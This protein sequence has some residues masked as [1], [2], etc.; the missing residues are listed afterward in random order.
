MA[1]RF[2][3]TSITNLGNVNDP[4]LPQDA[5]TKAY[6]DALAGSLNYEV[7]TVYTNA[8]V[9]TATITLASIAPIGNILDLAV[10][11]GTGTGAACGSFVTTKGVGQVW[12]FLGSNVTFT[13]ASVIV[14]DADTA[15]LTF[16]SAT[17]F[18]VALPFGAPLQFFVSAQTLTPFR[19]IIAGAGVGASVAPDADLVPALT[20]TASGGGGGSSVSVNG[21][22]IASPNF[23]SNPVALGTN[24]TVAGSNITA[25]V[26]DADVS[27]VADREVGLLIGSST[28][29]VQLSNGSLATAV[30]ISNVPGPNVTMTIATVTTAS[31]ILSVLTG[32]GANATTISNLF[33]LGS[34]TLVDSWSSPLALQIVATFPAATTLAQVQAV[35]APGGVAVR[36]DSV[37]YGGPTTG[38]FLFQPLPRAAVI[39]LGGGGGGTPGGLTTQVQFN[40]N[41]VFGGSSNLVWDGTTLSTNIIGAIASPLSLRSTVAVNIGDNFANSIYMTGAGSGSLPSIRT[42]STTDTNVNL[43]IVPLGTGGLQLG[44]SVIPTPL[45]VA[46]SAT[47][48]PSI[49]LTPGIA[50]QI[51]T[52]AGEAK[53]P[54]WAALSAGAINFDSITNTFINA[55]VGTLA[56]E[57]QS[58]VTGLTTSIVITNEGTGDGALLKAFFDNNGTSILYRFVG[59]TI[60][61]SVASTVALTTSVT[62]TLGAPTNFLTNIPALT[63]LQVQQVVAAPFNDVLLAAPLSG[64]VATGALGRATLTITGGVTP[65]GANTQIQFNNNGVL[66][67]SAGL[68]WNGTQLGTN[69]I[70]AAASSTLSLRSDTGVRIQDQLANF[71]GLNGNLAGSSPSIEAQG[72][73]TNVNLIVYGKGTGGIQIGTL[74]NATPLIAADA[75]VQ[76]ALTPGVSGQILT[77]S[78]TG[79]TPYWAAL[80][81]GAINFDSLTNAFV[82]AIVS[83]L[84][85]ECLSTVAGL[86]TTIVISN[87]G[88]GAGPAIKTF[89]DNNGTS[90]FYRFT[91]DTQTFTVASTISSPSQVTITLGTPTNFLGNIPG[92][93]VL[94]VQQV[95]ARPFNDLVLNAPLSGV[96]ATGALGRATLTITGGV[97]PGG[98][99]TQIQFNNNGAL[100]GSASL[101]WLGASGLQLGTLATPAPLV[102][103]DSATPTTLTPG[104][105]G[106]VLTSAGVGKTPYWSSSTPSGSTTL[107]GLT[108]VA[109]TEPVYAQ[110]GTFTVTVVT[111]NIQSITLS[112]LPTGLAVGDWL[113]GG[114]VLPGQLPALQVIFISGNSLQFSIDPSAFFAVGNFVYKLPTTLEGSALFFSN[115]QN[116]WIAEPPNNT[117]P[118]DTLDWV[119]LAGDLFVTD[120][121]VAIFDSAVTTNSVV[122]SNP[123]TFPVAILPFASRSEI[124]GIDTFGRMVSGKYL[125]AVDSGTPTAVLQDVLIDRRGG[126]GF[127]LNT[128]YTLSWRQGK[129]ALPDY[130]RFNT[131]TNAIIQGQPAVDGRIAALIGS[132]PSS[133]TNSGTT[134]VTSGF[135]NAGT[136][137]NII[138]TGYATAKAFLQTPAIGA[139]PVAGGL[140]NWTLPAGWTIR[141]SNVANPTATQLASVTQ[142]TE[143]QANS[144]LQIVFLGNASYFAN[145][146]AT[147]QPLFFFGTSGFIFQP[148]PAGAIDTEVRKLQVA[149]N[150]VVSALTDNYSLTG[151]AAPFFSRKISAGL[152][153]F[154][155][156]DA[157]GAARINATTSAGGGQGWIVSIQISWDLVVAS[158]IWT[159]NNAFPVFFAD[160]SV[161]TRFGVNGTSYLGNVT[162]LN[163]DPSPT[164]RDAQKFGNIYAEWHNTQA[165]ALTM[166]AVV[167]DAYNVSLQTSALPNNVNPTQSDAVVQALFNITN[168]NSQT[169]GAN[170]IG[171]SITALYAYQ[172]ARGGSGTVV[173]TLQSLTDVSIVEPVYVQVGTITVTSVTFATS[174]ILVSDASGI[175]VGDWLRGGGSFPGQLPALK[176]SSKTGNSIQFAFDPTP[177]FAIGNFVYRLPATLDG[178]PLSFSN[179]TNKWVAGTGGSSIGSNFTSFVI[180]N[181]GTG[182]IVSYATTYSEVKHS[183]IFGFG[184][185]Q[186]TTALDG[187]YIGTTKYLGT[188]QI[189]VTPGYGYAALFPVATTYTTIEVEIYTPT[190]TF[191]FTTDVITRPQDY[192]IE[193]VYFSRA[194][195]TS[196][197][198]PYISANIFPGF[199][200]TIPGVDG[201][202]LVPI[203]P[204]EMNVIQVGT[205]GMSFS[206]TITGG[207]YSGVVNNYNHTATTIPYL[208]YYRIW[209]AFGS[210]DFSD[211]TSIVLD[212]T[213]IGSYRALLSL[214]TGGGGGGGNQNLQQVL[215]LGNRVVS[216]TPNVGSILLTNSATSKTTVL[217]GTKVESQSLILD[218]ATTGSLILTVPATT[219]NYSLT[220]PPAQATAAGQTL[221]NNGSGTLSWVTPSGGGGTPGG[222][223]NQFQYNNAGAFAGTVGLTFDSVNI[224]ASAMP[225]V[226]GDNIARLSDV[227][228][229]SAGIVPR[230]T[231]GILL[232]IAEVN[233]AGTYSNNSGSVS[234][235]ATL[236]GLVQLTVASTVPAVGDEVLLVAQTAGLQNGS[237]VVTVNGVSGF[238]LTRT[239]IVP[240]FGN[241]WVA[242]ARLGTNYGTQYENITTGTITVGTTPILYALFGVPNNVGTQDLQA[243]CNIGPTTTTAMNV[244]GPLTA[245][246]TSGSTGNVIALAGSL[247]GI[248]PSITASGVDANVGL[249]IATK[250]IGALT[251]S[252]SVTNIGSNVNT[253]RILST[254]GALSPIISVV[255]SANT[256]LNIGANGTGNINLGVNQN[257]Y[258]RITPS[259][260]TPTITGFGITDTSLNIAPT[261][262]GKVIIGNTTDYTGLTIDSAGG[263]GTVVLGATGGLATG[264]VSIVLLPKG[265]GDIFPLGTSLSST[266]PNQPGIWLAANKGATAVDPGA[267]GS[268]MTSNY[269]DSSPY[270]GFPGANMT[271]FTTDTNSDIT[272]NGKFTLRCFLTA[273]NGLN[274]SVGTNPILNLSN[275]QIT[276]F[277]A[278]ATYMINLTFGW[279]VY[280]TQQRNVEAYCSVTT[281]NDVVSSVPYGNGVTCA[282][283][284]TDNV[285][286]GD[287]TFVSATGYYVSGASAQTLYCWVYMA[288]PSGGECINTSVTFTRI[289]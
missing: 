150:I 253:V 244:G 170:A 61:F 93:T 199:A 175:S 57:C 164:L 38:T 265:A 181:G 206:A 187:G 43:S 257:N 140:G 268:V 84:V 197:N 249:Q 133:Y 29:R 242:T 71:I 231:A 50:G 25:G 222:L 258:I 10:S 267:Y 94:Q 8:T 136:T 195:T 44:T 20:L 102:V 251:L 39:A 237:Y 179:A 116:K 186:D 79:K 224:R 149:P 6:T 120:P 248:A 240:A 96:V 74:S 110:V 108:D 141:I 213:V 171:F 286:V 145:A 200:Q 5:S 168:S 86:T 212:P 114:T 72:S 230:N 259:S 278:N 151:D 4:I 40:N 276:G 192:V 129:F 232:H 289:A 264:S 68:T 112:A 201:I 235:F 162:D 193:G 126:G 218:G 109:I 64:V 160:G 36:S 9:G 45:I 241:F 215:N 100:G 285:L 173:T 63:N 142:I 122:F 189:G 245:G 62:I 252:A 107:Q 203:T 41:G 146:G 117:L 103:V 18:G 19:R 24:L 130:V 51:L 194:D 207:F 148:A 37:F 49:T 34:T 270:W 48:T 190:L 275:G 137:A 33:Q 282:S 119:N 226:I 132:V 69:I 118:L 239:S 75:A 123:W 184:I 32:L 202:K 250:G 7:P 73:D 144:L 223:N 217:D 167:E 111:A 55:L 91:G 159:G 47:Q 182:T 247:V 22:L 35:F 134:T 21:V 156:T 183:I 115:A 188:T 105:T 65:G 234:P 2:D 131:A 246:Y 157:F 78:G 92:L 42:R 85:I 216:S 88:T 56:V 233:I 287:L 205:S 283:V 12:R 273:I 83:G 288:N 82:D 225:P 209:S 158:P 98:A 163:W 135:G 256:S 67:G 124:V 208:A 255:G 138:T 87:Q 80:S 191:N 172:R 30:V 210:P 3:F 177:F 23:Q 77:S 263:Q 28:N 14:V 227:Q 166:M 13:V 104:T 53:T 153:T 106:Q 52:S 274:L 27:T 261:G 101:A 31:T 54:Y 89:F 229:A 155:D 220:L 204:A 219:S 97:T 198:P 196:G 17:N 70:S 26:R 262:L 152:N 154:W 174:S 165:N 236:V 284:R 214:P 211:P 99:N 169:A 16:G 221:S 260:T 95:V 143:N 269:T 76:T 280:G 58:A 277:N 279:F 81:A 128:V 46:N 11:A 127:S 185:L 125:S 243:V 90:I 271:I 139:I 281:T 15:L 176:V 1:I 121:T 113:R 228:S 254:A 66:G 272:S 161:S 180:Q 238:T 266:L 147:A 60:T 178:Y 59:S